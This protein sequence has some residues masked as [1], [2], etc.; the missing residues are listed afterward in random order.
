M[1][2][3]VLL[4][5]EVSPLVPNVPIVH[6]DTGNPTSYFQTLIH[7]WLKEKKITEDQLFG[8]GLDGLADVD[9]V[10]DTPETGDLLVF[11][12]DF[13]VPLPNGDADQIL[14]SNGTGAI[15][16][17]EDNLGGGTACT[18]VQGAGVRFT[19][20]G[21]WTATLGATPTVGNI[22]FYIAVGFNGGTWK[23]TLPTGFT[24]LQEATPVT[25][26]YYR[27][28]FRVVQPGDGAGWSITTSGGA[29]DVGG[30]VVVEASG[31]QNVLITG[32]AAGSSG[33]VLSSPCFHGGTSYFTIT[34]FERDNTG[35]YVSISGATLL[36]D[37][38]G[39]GVNHPAVFARSSTTFGVASVTMSSGATNP[40]A[41]Q[42]K[43]SGT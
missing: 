18:Y 33:S 41:V 34:A 17:W 31:A 40:E 19:G 21:T 1:V 24:I 12:G 4:S 38:T 22:L 37:A 28:A 11:D 36:F 29:N 16:T 3:T 27:V 15:P 10:S 8:L 39:G 5:S 20:T 32:Q 14:T 25:N 9:T 7:T 23:T 13:W 30:F 43:I 35:T 2:D 26:Q 6:P 42:V